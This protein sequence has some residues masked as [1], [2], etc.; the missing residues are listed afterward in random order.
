MQ[1]NRREDDSILSQVLSHQLTMAED[2][3]GMKKQLNNGMSTDLKEIKLSQR[4]TSERLTKIERDGQDVHKKLDIHID[5]EE[6]TVTS[7][8]EAMTFIRTLGKVIIWLA[9]ASALVGLI[10]AIMNIG[11]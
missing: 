4:L 2:V 10:T 6:D 9:G 5:R 1:P 11:V 3:A 7:L 8:T